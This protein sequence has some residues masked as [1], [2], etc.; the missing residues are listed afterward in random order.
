MDGSSLSCV[1]NCP[2]IDDFEYDLMSAKP[3]PGIGHHPLIPANGVAKKTQLNN[4]TVLEGTL[5]AELKNLESPGSGGVAV[6]VD[7]SDQLKIQ[8]TVKDRTHSR[9]QRSSLHK[10]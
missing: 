10:T 7:T 9:R 5:T 4:M 2:S 8:V 1:T 6:P 3:D